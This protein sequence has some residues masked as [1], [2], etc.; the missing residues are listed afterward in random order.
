MAIFSVIGF[1]VILRILFYIPE[2][3]MVRRS[4]EASSDCQRRAWHKV[5]KTVHSIMYII[6][7]DW[8]AKG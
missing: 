6:A 8:Q 2:N 5:K 4:L 1:F 7:N 3:T